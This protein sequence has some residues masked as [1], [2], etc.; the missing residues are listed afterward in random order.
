MYTP[1]SSIWGSQDLKAE[2]RGKKVTCDLLQMSGE[3]GGQSYFL[4]ATPGSPS[5]AVLL[6]VAWKGIAA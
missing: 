6:L 3:C 4:S 1:L 5:R 2:K